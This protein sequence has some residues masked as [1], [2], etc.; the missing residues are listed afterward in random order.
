MPITATQIG[1]PQLQFTSCEQTKD[2][3]ITQLKES[4]T[5]HRNALCWGNIEK[6]E[7][8]DEYQ[9]YSEIKTPKLTAITAPNGTNLPA[10]HINL[11]TSKGVIRSQ[12]PTINAIP[13][14]LEMLAEKRVTVLVVI[15]EEHV[16]NDKQKSYPIYFKNT[17]YN[18]GEMEDVLLPENI[19]IKCYKLHLENKQQVNSKLPIGIPVIH[20]NNWPDCTSLSVEQLKELATYVNTVNNNKYSIYETAGSRAAAAD[21]KALPVIHC[22]AGIGRTGQLIAAMELINPKSL[23]SLESIIK[24]LREQGGYKMVQ[25][26]EQMD[27]LIDLAT[28]LHKPLWAKDEQHPQRAPSVSLSHSASCI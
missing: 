22:H 7:I 13:S 1:S 20:V 23:L 2:I 4:L 27:V 8:K 25:T 12:F 5:A 26:E 3:L 15:A 16:I 19:P 6:S 11:G 24:T 10:N 9:R 21:Q 14:F 18:H 17:V 28:Q